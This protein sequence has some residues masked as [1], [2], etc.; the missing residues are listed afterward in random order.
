MEYYDLEY[1]VCLY[2]GDPKEEREHVLPQAKAKNFVS[3]KYDY[4]SWIVPSCWE[5]NSIASDKLF[6]TF[7]DKQK[8]IHI[9][10]REKYFRQLESDWTDTEIEE[11]GHSLKTII[12]NDQKVAKWIKKRLRYR[13][14]PMQNVCTVTKVL[15]KPS[16]G[17]SSVQETRM[18]RKAAAE[19]NTTTKKL[20]SLFEKSEKKRK[21]CKNC[22]DIFDSVRGRKYCTDVCSKE[23]YH[24]Q[25][26]AAIR[27]GRY[28][29]KLLNRGVTS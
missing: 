9:G 23:W 5:C 13:M 7:G 20:N 15:K 8:Y 19:V 2:C 26:F 18:E 28:S 4:I 11:L 22:G 10:I 21:A 12:L 3:E 25:R 16:P 17:K 29:E 6:K 27:K 1:P 14:G 24:G